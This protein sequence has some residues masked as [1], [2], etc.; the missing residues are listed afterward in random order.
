MCP[1]W[2]QHKAKAEACVKMSV[3]GCG[4]RVGGTKG[5]VREI[6]LSS[7]SRRPKC[8]ADGGR[9][10]GKA[11]VLVTTLIMYELH[12]NEQDCRCCYCGKESQY[13]HDKSH[14]SS[15]R[16]ARL[17]GMKITTRE[18][19]LKSLQRQNERRRRRKE[20]EDDG[21]RLRVA[22]QAFPLF[23]HYIIYL[24]TWNIH[25]C[26]LCLVGIW[27]LA[28]RHLSGLAWQERVVKLL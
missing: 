10:A 14:L 13:W 3:G 11:L 12:L 24:F 21:E 17:S 9:I 25:I 1:E 18:L 5:F 19:H 4:R 8:R 2:R 6:C 20:E 27:G 15:D 7:C 16:Q 22:L 28:F 26:P 23:T